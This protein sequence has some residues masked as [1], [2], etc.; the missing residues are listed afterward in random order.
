MVLAVQKLSRICGELDKVTLEL[1]SNNGQ[2][3]PS[4]EKQLDEIEDVFTND[5][6]GNLLYIG[7][8]I[9]SLRSLLE[10]AKAHLS[11]SDVDNL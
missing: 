6:A 10:D 2:A 1:V 7:V 11:P 8:R 9:K 5:I 3:T 4:I